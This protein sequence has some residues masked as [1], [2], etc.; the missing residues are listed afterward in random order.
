VV[1]E[2][3]LT[4]LP[5]QPLPEPITA[6]DLGVVCWMRVMAGDAVVH[7]DS[8][9]LASDL[10]EPGITPIAHPAA[11]PDA[12]TPIADMSTRSRPPSSVDRV[13]RTSS[14]PR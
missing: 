13:I 11:R 7:I 10:E 1:G 3:G 12:Q 6:D 8:C 2:Y 4:P 5:P 9:Q 14:M